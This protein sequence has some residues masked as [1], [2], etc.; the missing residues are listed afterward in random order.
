MRY[1]Y[2]VP[3]GLVLVAAALALRG[4]PLPSMGWRFVLA[5]AAGGLAQVVG[6]SLLIMAFGYRN[7]AVGTA[8]AKTDAVQA[9]LLGRG[10]AA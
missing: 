8:Y 5:C 2:A 10:A 9:A 4:G 3:V 1:V 7:F 6:T